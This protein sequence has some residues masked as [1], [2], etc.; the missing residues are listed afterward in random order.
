HYATPAEKLAASAYLGEDADGTNWAFI[1]AAAGSVADLCVIP[2]GDVLGLG[3]DGRMNVPSEADGNW[4][5]RFRRDAL[6]PELTKKLAELATVSDRAPLQAAQ[7]RDG[8]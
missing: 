7:Q 8:E 6:T 2:L 1:R 4:A 3:A 5:W